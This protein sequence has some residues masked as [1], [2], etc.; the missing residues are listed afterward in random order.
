[1]QQ[2]CRCSSV[3]PKFDIDFLELSPQRPNE[4]VV[5]KVSRVSLWL[6]KLMYVCFN[7][8]EPAYSSLA[9]S[10]L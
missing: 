8:L 3:L 4:Y 9:S 5:F 2:N 1:M 10:L 6:L 7:V